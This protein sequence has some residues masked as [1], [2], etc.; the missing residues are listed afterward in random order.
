[1]FW[2][3][4]CANT[5]PVTSK[6]LAAKAAVSA[7]GLCR[8][9]ATAPRRNHILQPQ[10]YTDI[11]TTM[12]YVNLTPADVGR[13]F[14]R[15]VAARKAPPRSHAYDTTLGRG[16]YWELRRLATTLRPS[17]LGHFRAVTA[18]F[19]GYLKRRFAQARRTDQMRRDPH[20]LGWMEDLA[21]RQPPLATALR[22]CSG[23]FAYA[24][25]WRAWRTC[26][27]LPGRH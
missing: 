23:C 24:G 22:A 8:R 25:F 13:E 14:A 21:H 1:M 16:I 3:A 17:T 4:P 2:A 19:L 18:H 26:R 27:I 20:I 7:G 6:C 11:P 5:D 9:R 15:A 12:L 10:G